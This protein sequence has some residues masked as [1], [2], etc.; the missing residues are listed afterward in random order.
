MASA[1]DSAPAL[2]GKQPRST[3]SQSYLWIIVHKT[4]HEESNPAPFTPALDQRGEIESPLWPRRRDLNTQLHA[5]KTCTL[6]LRHSS[7]HRIPCSLCVLRYLLHL[8]LCQRSAQPTPIRLSC[9]PI[10]NERYNCCSA[11]RNACREA[12]NY[13]TELFSTHAPNQSCSVLLYSACSRLF[14]GCRTEGVRLALPLNQPFGVYIDQTAQ[15]LCLVSTCYPL[16][17]LPETRLPELVETKGI[18]PSTSCLQGRHATAALRPHVL[19]AQERAGFV[20]RF[21]SG[22]L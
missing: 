1:S 18:E 13:G 16:P 7:T 9:N 14:T 20:W 15:E 4:Y 5:P 19:F 11:S 12:R 8:D 21:C 10:L 17:H 6:P 2:T 22:R 3:V